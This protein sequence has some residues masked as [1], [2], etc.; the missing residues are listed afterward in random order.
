[1]I[2]IGRCDVC[3]WEK[4]STTVSMDGCLTF[5]G[6]ATIGSGSV[7]C[8]NKSG[9]CC[10]GEK[11]R[12]TAGASLI[13]RHKITLGSN[14]LISWDT[15]IMDSDHHLIFNAGN[16]LLNPDAP[17]Q[18]GNNVWIGCRSTL[19]KGTAVPDGCIVAAG[20]VLT[21]KFEEN[22]SIIGGSGSGQRVIRSEVNWKA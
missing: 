3:G 5:Q 4:R 10:I 13:C 6:K 21:G 1:M 18:I 14:V 8:I 9:I 17:V 16:K 12:V 20:A 11:F 22:N 2:K 15:L 7:L 19:L